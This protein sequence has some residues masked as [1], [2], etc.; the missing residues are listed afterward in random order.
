MDDRLLIDAVNPRLLI[1]SLVLCGAG[2]VG[3][4]LTYGPPVT[5][6]AAGVSMLLLPIVAYGTQRSAEQVPH[7]I[8]TGRALLLGAVQVYSTPTRHTPGEPN[9]ADPV[10]RTRSAAHAESSD[11]GDLR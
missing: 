5:Y 1:L 2:L 4:H 7:L 10:D 3:V 11:P 8:R 9:H 6:I